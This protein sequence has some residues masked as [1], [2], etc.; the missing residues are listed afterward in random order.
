MAFSGFIKARERPCTQGRMKK[1][2]N[3][4]AEKERTTGGITRGGLKR[5]SRLWFPWFL[6]KE[7]EETN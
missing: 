7:T 1:G 2:Q 5:R 6:L 3:R 4:G